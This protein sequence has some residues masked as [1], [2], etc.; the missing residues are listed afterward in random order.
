MWGRR[1][2]LELADLQLSRKSSRRL[3]CRSDMRRP[4]GL[5]PFRPVAA[6]T[7]QFLPVFGPS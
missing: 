6:D 5:M 1:G 3:V 4:N 7:G 2:K